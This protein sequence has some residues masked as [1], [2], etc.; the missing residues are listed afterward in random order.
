MRFPW[1]TIAVS[2]VLLFLANPSAVYAAYTSTVVGSIAT[3]TGDAGSDA[4]T[5]TQSGGL[6]RHLRFSLGGD[7]GFNSDFDFDTTVPGDQTVSATTG[8]ININAGDGNDQIVL[9]NVDLRGTIDGGPGND[10]ISYAF[11]GGADVFANLGLGTTGLAATLG[12][13]QENPPTTSAATGTATV[14]NYNINTHTFDITVTV[15]GITPA[16][17]TGFHIHQAPVGGN[18]PIVIDFTALGPPLVASGTGFTYSAAG[19]LLPAV[20]EAA[21]LGGGIYV[22]VHTAVFP[23]GAIRGQLFTGGNVNLAA[24][25]ATGTTGIS[26]IENVNGGVGNDSLVGSFAVNTIAGG[27]GAD[28]IVG[29]PGADVL[30]GDAGADVLVWSNGDGSDVDEGGADIDTVQVNGG[31]AGIDVFTIAANGARID[32]DRTNV[33]LFSLDIGTSEALTVNGIGGDDSFTVSNLTG[34]AALATLNLNGFDGNDSFTLPAVAGAV[35]VNALGGPGAD[36][37]NYSTFTTAISANLGLGSTGL[38]ATISAD[39]EAPPTTHAGTGTAAVTN[40]N[41]ATHTF[42]ITVTVSN[43]PPSDVTGFHIHQAPVGIN[44]PIIVD[45]TGVAPLVPAG[46]GFTFTATGLTL[47]A[48]SE[49]AFL[50][51]G[52]YVN[53]HT[54]TFTGGAIRGQLFSGGNLN[55][56]SGTA[57]GAAVVRAIENVTGG[58]GDDSLVGSFAVNTLS[59]G[60]GAEWIVGGPGNDILNGDAGADV[61]VWSNG[62]GTDV[63]EGGADGDTV[64]VN[65]RTGA[66]DVFT[67]AANGTRVR[68]DRTN[69]GLFSLDIGTV[70]TLIVNGIGGD[71]TMTVGNLA[72]V[73]DLTT[74]RMNGFDGNDT[75]TFPQFSGPATVTA[76]GGPGTNT[77]ISSPITANDAYATGFNAPLAIAAPGVLANDNANGGGAITA[78]LVATTSS[79]ALVFNADGSFVYTPGV[80]FVG[81]DSFTYRATNPIG[82]GNVASVTIAVNG[83]TDPQPPSGLRVSSVVG[84]VVTFRWIPPTLGPAPTEYVVEGGITAGQV[85]ASLPTGSASPIFTVAAP[86]GTFYVRV[87]TLAGAAQSAPSNEIIVYV[88]VPVAP[89]APAGLVG[90]VNGSS[91]EFAWRNTFGG[92]A[93]SNVF[94]DVSGS[95]SASVS[96]GLRETVSF[97]VVP[98]GN[99]TFALRAANAWGTS[100][101]SNAISL[102]VPSACTGAPL[103]PENFLAYKIGNTAYVVWEPAATGAASTGYVLLVDGGFTLSLPTAQRAISGTVPA[104]TYILSVMATNACGS[105]APTATQTVVIP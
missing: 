79:G 39:Q 22:N 43:L 100:G 20:S 50:G 48:T 18:G 65:G 32:F 98:A 52:T 7:P 49:A 61:L 97:P 16:E 56:T 86:T 14:S 71:D 26:N 47:P 75:F 101:S 82:A 42:D 53:V 10:T 45:F 35:A 1:R 37:L 88:N 4:L 28:W 51:G 66:G 91:L 78:A 62:D 92:G 103:P 15:S 38:S 57:T 8:T 73:A 58:S 30:N 41:I 46:T 55:L 104:G 54:A 85:L 60:A 89:T 72:G 70:E 81:T 6:F 27:A 33:G 11:F 83:P 59:G 36:T 64:Q 95:L 21:L 23:D 99:Y 3:M 9:N 105:S 102:S 19:V 90:V 12:A 69:L 80:N 74:V 87:R 96:L 17:V 13:D 44:G 31:T 76:L 84:N 63:D 93:P 24:G 34:I 25:A 29:G 67:V 40:Y 77:I 94:L 68:F 2:A 5:I